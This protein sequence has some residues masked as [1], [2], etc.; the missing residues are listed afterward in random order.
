VVAEAAADADGDA[1]LTVIEEPE[2]V[3]RYEHI[4]YPAHF[5]QKCTGN[6]RGLRPWP[7]SCL[8]DP[9]RVPWKEISAKIERRDGSY[10]VVL[11][12][13]DVAP[14]EMLV[15]KAWLYGGDDEDGSVCPGCFDRDRAYGA[16]PLITK[17]D[18]TAPDYLSYATIDPSGANF[19]SIQH[20]LYEPDMDIE[21]LIQFEKR[22][23]Q[24]NEVLTWN[25]DHLRFEGILE[26]MRA[27]AVLI[28]QPLTHVVLEKNAMNR[29]AAQQEIWRRWEQT[30]GIVTIQHE[31][32]SNKADPELGVEAMCN[33]YRFG[34]VRLPGLSRRD[35]LLVRPFTDELVTATTSN[36]T[37]RKAG[38]G[39]MAAWFGVYQRDNMLRRRRGRGPNGSTAPKKAPLPWKPTGLRRPA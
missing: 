31:T 37:G 16:A 25:F 33:R 13:Q 4:V 9:V 8:I 28:H 23:L 24:I 1:E 6:H 14:H 26:D 38:D 30:H 2:Y 11:Q 15:R 18:R 17:M 36:G 10:E 3:K 12:Q 7:E 19:W 22:K 34:K 39:M 5:E 32:Q 35:E 29:W 21:W 20:W 27:H